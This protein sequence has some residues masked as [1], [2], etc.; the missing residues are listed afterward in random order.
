MSKKELQIPPEPPEIERRVLLSLKQICSIL[1]IL[2]IPLLALIGVFGPE[3]KQLSIDGV[4]VNMQIEYPAMT[5]NGLPTKF[6]ISLLNKSAQD[7]TMLRA[8]IDRSYLK[9]FNGV[10]STPEIKEINNDNYV[11]TFPN[12]PAGETRRLLIDLQPQRIGRHKG[13]IIISDGES[14]IID[15]S[16]HTVILP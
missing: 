12:I 9:N 11:I 2:L 15:L 5:R 13:T 3:S 1:F 16:M 7:L 10:R 14:D 6:Q 4:N 8:I